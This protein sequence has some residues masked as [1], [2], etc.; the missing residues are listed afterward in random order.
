MTADLPIY[1][2]RLGDTLIGN[3]WVEVRHHRLLG[4]RWRT[5]MTRAPEAGFFGAMLWF[6]AYR[7]NPAGTLPDDDDEL[8]HLAGLGLDVD[9]WRGLRAVGALY[10][11]APHLV[12]GGDDADDVVRLGHATVAEVALKSFGFQRDRKGK[13]QDGVRR[14]R[15]SRVRAQFPG[16][17][18]RSSLMKSERFAG[19]VLDWLDARKQTITAAN[20]R[21]AVEEMSKGAVVQMTDFKTD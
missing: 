11:W 19:Q 2:L 9:R 17:G 3:E 21:L 5:L 16:I 20:V 15:L 14:K 6:E 12:L 4:S 8:A 18:L 1:P 10:G 7:Q 13:S